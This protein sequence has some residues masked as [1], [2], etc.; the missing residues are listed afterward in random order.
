MI[1]G[2]TK[3]KDLKTLYQKAVAERDLAHF[4]LNGEDVTF[5]NDPMLFRNQES[6]VNDGVLKVEGLLGHRTQTIRSLESQVWR[7]INQRSNL[8]RIRNHSLESPEG[9]KRGEFSYFNDDELRSSNFDLL[10]S[11][12]LISL[13]HPF[14]NLNKLK[15]VVFDESILR[16]AVKYFNAIPIISYAKITISFANKLKDSDTQWY[17]FDFGSYKI[18]KCVVYLNEVDILGGP[19]SYVKTSHQ[20]KFRGWNLKSRFSE[21]ELLL[22]YPKDAFVKCISS[23]GDVIFA[24]TTGLHRGSKP[25]SRHRAVL[26]FNFTIHPEVGFN[27]EKLKIPA[28]AYES[29]NS[30]QKLF[31]SKEIFEVL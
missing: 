1:Y 30:F 9:I 24:E 4:D 21:E 31:F 13:R 5:Q 23:P 15:D 17:H 8:S 6:L 18:L 25:I 27:W 19:F 20:K 28:H 29:L 22:H 12:S 26:I 14:M 2:F 16:F 7:N 10:D 3:T 11:V